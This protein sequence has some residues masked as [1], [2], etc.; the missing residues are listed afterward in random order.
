MHPHG[1]RTDELSRAVHLIGG[2]GKKSLP[3][4]LRWRA[5]HDR[6][7]ATNR[8]RRRD[9]AHCRTAP[10]FALLP[11]SSDASPSNARS[12]P[13]SDVRCPLSFPLTFSLSRAFFPPQYTATSLEARST[14]HSQ[15]SW[16]YF[17]LLVHWRLNKDGRCLRASRTTSRTRSRL[18]FGSG[19]VT[20]ISAKFV[21][22]YLEVKRKI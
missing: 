4:Y 15:R 11:A 17:V 13:M 1:T 10:Y 8:Q 21:P 7:R 16:N 3:L 22:L 5:A 19:T 2:K 9:I 18:D 12:R 6:S 20:K 14:W